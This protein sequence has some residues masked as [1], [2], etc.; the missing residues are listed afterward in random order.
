MATL[1]KFNQIKSENNSVY[2]GFGLLIAHIDTY[3]PVSACISSSSNGI[4]LFF[5]VFFLKTYH[6]SEERFHVDLLSSTAR[7]SSF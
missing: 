2:G 7:T 4:L 6:E 5:F 1:V 3:V